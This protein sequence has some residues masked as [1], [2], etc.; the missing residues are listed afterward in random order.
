MISDDVVFTKAGYDAFL[1]GPAKKSAVAE[2][3]TADTEGSEA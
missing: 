3:E 1:A 2:S